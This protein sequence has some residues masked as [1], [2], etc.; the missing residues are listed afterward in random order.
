[1]NSGMAM[2][3]SETIAMAADRPNRRLWK[4][5]T[6]TIAG[7]TLTESGG[8]NPKRTNGSEKLLMWLSVAS[9]KA[10]PSAPRRYGSTYGMRKT[11]R[12]RARPRYLFCVTMAAAT[13]IGRVTIVLISANETLIQ[14][15]AGRPLLM[16]ST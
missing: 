11:A 15:E 5:V 6:Y 7:M 14:I 8:G 9:R 13:P 12:T 16:A 3:I 2:M 4:L 1:M 10:S